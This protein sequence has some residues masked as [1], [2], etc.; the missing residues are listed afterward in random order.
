MD[1]RGNAYSLGTVL[2]V[3][4]LPYIVPAVGKLMLAKWVCK[5]AKKEGVKYTK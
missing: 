5:R 3:C 4:V 1:M 2:S